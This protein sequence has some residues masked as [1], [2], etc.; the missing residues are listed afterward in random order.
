MQS[1]DC[2][3]TPD[4]RSVDL[5]TGELF[6]G[7]CGDVIEPYNNQPDRLAGD[8]AVEAIAALLRKQGHKIGSVVCYGVQNTR[9]N[10]FWVSARVVS[11][12]ERNGAHKQYSILRSGV[13]TL[14]A[15]DGIEAAK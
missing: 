7:D 11:D 5:A 1:N 6:C 14:T 10:K 8:D 15:F 3:H 13:S 12:K 9:P 2:T 4:V